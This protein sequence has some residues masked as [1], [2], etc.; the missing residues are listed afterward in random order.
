MENLCALA[1]GIRDAKLLRQ[2]GANAAR[3]GERPVAARYLRQSL[4]LNPVSEC[5]LAAR[6]AR[7]K[8]APAATPV[9][10]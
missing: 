4:D 3:L 6:A 5:S 8:L 2:A 1:V 9:A 7:E 10:R